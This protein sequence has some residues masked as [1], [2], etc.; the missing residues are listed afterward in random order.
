MVR[1]VLNISFHSGL[2][3]PQYYAK[4]HDSVEE[5]NWPRN[6]ILEDPRR[7]CT[8]LLAAECRPRGTA[9]QSVGTVSSWR[10]LQ[11]L[12]YMMTILPIDQGISGENLHSPDSETI[13]RKECR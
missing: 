8:A 9:W 12:V 4:T 11:R 10:S 6:A 13:C 3:V 5:V 2:R 7:H 1:E